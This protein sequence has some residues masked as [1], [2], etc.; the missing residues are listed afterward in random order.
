MAANLGRV[1]FP[2]RRAG[3]Y[4]RFPPACR[5]CCAKPACVAGD[6]A[7][8]VERDQGQW[9]VPCRDGSVSAASSSCWRPGRPAAAS[10]PP[11]PGPSWQLGR[12]L[13]LP[14]PGARLQ[15][16]AQFQR[17][18]V[19]RRSGEFEDP[20]P[21]SMPVGA[22]AL[23]RCWVRSAALPP[24]WASPSPRLGWSRRCGN[25]RGLA[26]PKGRA[27]RRSWRGARGLLH[28]RDSWAGPLPE[29]GSV[30]LQWFSGGFAGPCLG[31]VACGCPGDGQRYGAAAAGAVA[32]VAAL[33]F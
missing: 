24:G 8:R 21:S 33:L 9:L 26:L 16:P 5:R 15:L 32:G 13:E 17:P 14:P 2:A 12:V 1:S 22:A 27:R 28:N 19:E 3:R 20:V 7:L 4:R 31:T 11:G 29:P 30:W 23:A 6:E 25:H 10:G 18:A